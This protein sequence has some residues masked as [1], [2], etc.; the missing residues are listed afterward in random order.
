MAVKGSIMWLLRFGTSNA[1]EE[2]L[3]AEAVKMRL[4]IY[5]YLSIYPSISIYLSIYIYIYLSIYPPI[6][7]YLS[8]YMYAYTYI[9]TTIY[10]NV[11]SCYYMCP[12]ATNPKPCVYICVLMLQTLNRV[13][14]SIC[15]YIYYIYMYYI[16]PYLP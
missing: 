9:C 4:S 14:A 16:Y 6:S 2:T 5:I 1:A 3:Q 12:H 8:I 10:Y 15:I 11:S 7:I 13:C